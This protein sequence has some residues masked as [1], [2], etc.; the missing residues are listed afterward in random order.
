M[1]VWIV[2]ALVLAG[3]SLLGT[4]LHLVLAPRG[5]AWIVWALGALVL[6]FLA[7]EL[8]LRARRRAG[9][10]G[11]EERWRA[12]LEDPALRRAAVREL[13]A[14]IERARR[15]G[16]RTRVE[17]ARLATVLAELLVAGG[18]PEQAIAALAKVP[19][20]QLAP[21]EAAVVRHARAQA[22]LAAGD[23][24]GAEVA[25]APLGERAGDEVLD[26][27]IALAR[28]A[29]ALGRG[30]WDDA[31]RIAAAVAEAHDDEEL[32]GEATA[33]RAA[34]ASARGDAEG[35]RALA[36]SIH[37]EQR[38]RLALLGP[39]SLRAVLA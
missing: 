37:P 26:A 14:R 35:A 33:L 2:R 4:L 9:R 32:R 8:A 28:A 36:A 3:L 16:P 19:L 29:L 23:L 39:A 38:R 13:R 24:D 17:H 12:S 22:Y 11:D 31:E 1:R 5:L 21:I 15:L 34:C 10:E 6:A 7:L 30:A 25:L 27:A 18:E 20:D